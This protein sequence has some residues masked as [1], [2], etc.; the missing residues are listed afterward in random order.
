[1]IGSLFER[2]GVCVGLGAALALFLGLEELAFGLLFLAF[3]ISP[4]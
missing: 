3:L 4:N 1:M 2:V